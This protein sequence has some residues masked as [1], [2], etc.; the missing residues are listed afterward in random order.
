VIR[1]LVTGPEALVRRVSSHLAPVAR[2]IFR[3]R[4]DKRIAMDQI[5]SIEGLEIHLKRNA[6]SYAPGASERWIARHLLRFLPG[7]GE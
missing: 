3:G 7:T 1:N 4:F 6:A 5:V 2:W